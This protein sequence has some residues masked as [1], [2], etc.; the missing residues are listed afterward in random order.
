ML[1]SQQS[2]QG[3]YPSSTIKSTALPASPFLLNLRARTSPVQATSDQSSV[4]FLQ[5]SEAH[6]FATHV[7]LSNKT[8][9]SSFPVIL[10]ASGGADYYCNPPTLTVPFMASLPAPVPSVSSSYPNTFHLPTVSTVL[11]Q[12]TQD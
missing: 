6:S 10:I 11:P 1:Y 3:S 4:V 7:V 5:L 9:T 8:T 12:R 2:K